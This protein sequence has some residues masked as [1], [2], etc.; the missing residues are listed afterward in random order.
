MGVGIGMSKGDL[1]AYYPSGPRLYPNESRSDNYST[2]DPPKET[3]KKE[4]EKVDINPQPNNW[5]IIKTEEI[6]PFLIIKIKYPNCINYEG[7]KIMVYRSSL[8][9]LINQQLIDP[10]FMDDK[11]WISPIARFVP[12][13]DGW[14]MAKRFVESE[15]KNE[16]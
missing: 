10:H 3:K 8:V 15:I 6:A 5:K 12:T 1:R 2:Y 14:K 4:I 13:E 16:S 7:E 11:K 9:D